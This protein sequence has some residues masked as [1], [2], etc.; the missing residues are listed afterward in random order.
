MASRALTRYALRRWLLANGFEE[1]VGRR[2]GHRKF[3]HRGRGL[4]VV[5]VWHGRTDLTKKHI[6]MLIRDL[7]AAGFDRET[8]RKELLG[9]GQ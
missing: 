7:T 1:V 2:D 3:T 6:G 4:N 5:V 9:S 8:I